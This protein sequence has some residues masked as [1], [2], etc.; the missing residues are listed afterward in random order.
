MEFELEVLSFMSSDLIQESLVKKE[1]D[2]HRRIHMLVFMICK[3][4]LILPVLI[5]QFLMDTEALIV[6]SFSEQI[7][8]FF[9]EE[10]FFK[11]LIYQNI[12]MDLKKLDL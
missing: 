11:D 3:S 6:Q 7:F 2:K 1:G 5:M 9:F 10:N 12:L 8:I 4:L